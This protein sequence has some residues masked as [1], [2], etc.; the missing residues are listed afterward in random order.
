MNGQFVIRTGQETMEHNLRKPVPAINYRIH[1]RMTA[2]S[3]SVFHNRNKFSLLMREPTMTMCNVPRLCFRGMLVIGLLWAAESR[4]EI[5]MRQETE[6]IVSQHRSVYTKRPIGPN[7]QSV[8]A[9]LLGNGDVAVA[10]TTTPAQIKEH[11]GHRRPEQIRF[12]FMKN[13]FWKLGNSTKSRLFGY[14]DFTFELRGKDLPEREYRVETDLYTATTH[15]RISHGE[16]PALQFTAWVSAVDNMVYVQFSAPAGGEVFWVDTQPHLMREDSTWKASG[17]DGYDEM[18]MQRSFPDGEPPTGMSMSAKR[19]GKRLKRGKLNKEPQT[20]VFAI[21][22]LM[23][24]P[25]YAQAVVKK[26]AEFDISRLDEMYTTHKQWWADFWAKSFIEIPDQVIEKQYYLANYVLASCCRDKDFPPGIR[27]TWTCNDH[28]RWSNDYHLNYNFQAGFYSLYGSNHPELG[29][30]QDQPLLDYMP[31]G[32]KLA[33]ERLNM[34]GILYPVGIG[35]KGSTTW[36]SDYGQKSNASYGAVNMIFRWKTTRDLDYARKVYPYFQE[37]TTFWEAYL[38]Y[39]EENDRYVILKD[40]I[41]EQSG[42]D[43]NSVV[44]L[45]LCRAVFEAALDMSKELGVDATKHEKWNHILEHLSDYAT[46]QREGKTVFRYTEEGTEWW[47]GNTLGIQHIYPA[48]GIGLESDPRLIKIARN[49]IDVMQ[50]WSDHNGDNSFFPAAAYVGY[51]PQVIYEKLHEYA[52]NFYRPNGLRHSQGHGTEKLS[53]IPN[54][55]NMMLC[56]VH[57][58]I[59]RLYPAWP[60]DKDARFGNLRQFGAFLV[61]SELKQGVVRYVTVLSEKGRD[62]TLVNPWPGQAVTLKRN[63]AAAG[64]LSGQRLSIKTQPGEKLH[65]EPERR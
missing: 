4:S 25:H 14:I 5:A 6:R 11:L 64:T 60:M 55:I 19:F 45:A 47:K 33:R 7:Y 27:T 32:R 65:L 15:G 40:S 39:E 16:K 57:K 51:K 20:F 52:A 34:P 1:D 62:L 30:V 8:D 56:S 38:E 17:T 37:L 49:T 21:D 26:M 43:K 13:D 10:I 46:Q 54:T 41:H 61:S 48:L 63:G 23:K 59:M 53:T 9:V 58:G 22:S 42:K 44:S 12:W 24:N 50:R 18:H 29:E 28:P 31:V 36:G 2:V 3:A 35:P